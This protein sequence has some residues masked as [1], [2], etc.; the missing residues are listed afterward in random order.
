MTRFTN[1]ALNWLIGGL[2]IFGGSLNVRAAD[3]G[4]IVDVAESAGSF[5]TLLAAAQAA[6]LVETLT[7]KGP[8]TL[9]APTDEAF[10]KL[11]ESTLKDLLKPENKWKLQAILTYHVLP[12][13]VLAKDVLQLKSANTVFGQDVAV[14]INSGKVRINNANVLQTDI[15]ASNGVVHAIDS[16]LLPKDII[17]LA[18]STS[19]FETLIAAIDA[20]DLMATLKNDGPFTVF[21]PTDEAFVKLPAGTIENLLRPENKGKLQEILTYHVVPGRVLAKDVMKL[22]SVG[23]VSGKNLTISS[24]SAVKING[25]NLVK[26][27]VIALNG[28]IH[29]IDSVLLPK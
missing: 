27:D 17:D 19:M 28:V 29:V 20:A 22:K 18:N 2:L 26:T 24:A 21:A 8:L 9:F 6:D 25:A 12:G 7:G 10:A 11:P 5:Q 13:K 23:T 16:V 3:G 4:N 14:N 1:F 15:L